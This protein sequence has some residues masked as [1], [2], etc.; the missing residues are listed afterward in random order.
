MAL[1]ENIKVSAADV[2]DS[3]SPEGSVADAL[4][5][6]T[7]EMY[8]LAGEVDW[9]GALQRAIDTRKEVRLGN[10]RYTTSLPILIYSGTVLNGCGNQ[11][12]VIRKMGNGVYTDLPDV[13]GP[14]GNRV[15]N[16]IDA[17]LLFMPNQNDIN[18]NDQSGITRCVTSVSLSNFGIDRGGPAA[19][20]WD[21]STLKLNYLNRDYVV[22][23]SYG[24]GIRG[25]DCAENT[26]HGLYV[27]CFEDGVYFDNTWVNSFT[28]IIS[29]NRAP[30]TIVSGTSCQFRACYAL[31]ASPNTLSR[32]Y[33]AWDVNA[34][35]SSLVS[36]A[37]DGTG[38][39]GYRSQTIYKIGGQVSLIG[40]G[41]EVSHAVRA[42]DVAGYSHVTI[43]D[44]NVYY[45][46]NKYNTDLSAT[47]GAIRIG[48]AA[49]CTIK[50]ISWGNIAL[51][52]TVSISGSAP[53]PCYAE[54]G[55]AAVLD[56]SGSVW[57]G[58]E[59]QITGVSDSS[60]N[61]VYLSAGSSAFELTSLGTKL[62]YGP[63]S[64]DGQ[65]NGAHVN[66]NYTSLPIVI[67]DDLS[68]SSQSN[69]LEIGS[70]IKTATPSIAM[71]AA[72]TQYI[73]FGITVA[74]TGTPTA[75][76]QGS[77]ASYK[78]GAHQFTGTVRPETDNSTNLGSGS[79]RWA[80]VF[81]ANGTIQTSDATRKKAVASIDEQ[82]L[83]A[84]EQVQF[85]QYR[86]KEGEQRLHFG[87]LAQEVVAAFASVGLNALDYGVVVLEDGVY[88]VS[89]S[90]AMVLEMQLM[91]HK[92][93][94]LSNL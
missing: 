3:V 16:N 74:T 48:E 33:H 8:F 71:R 54:V 68:N 20:K 90:E 55:P 4:T 29:A 14:F 66:Q 30:F 36:C 61:Q 24:Y 45:Y 17:A 59:Y 73:D 52:S 79:N 1:V 25:Y 50:G 6:V 60:S 57:S 62:F 27:T 64:G 42:V 75:N 34:N 58:T 83:Q 7:P 88:G 5:Y 19:V 26:F 12:S 91:R 70:R 13:V 23:D 81:A 15:Y 53:K 21:P 82:V 93:D 56:I 9:T 41:S 22:V 38:R 76:Y 85:Y 89:Y 87:V 40:C 43:T 49:R 2:A 78:A 63:G 69:R 18:D 84:W 72:G 65:Y 10:R 51:S 94:K 77:V 92:L 86:W 46:Y 35:Y 37:A 44:M 80:A 31:N 11:H 67:A 39:D 28:N 47:R 32:V